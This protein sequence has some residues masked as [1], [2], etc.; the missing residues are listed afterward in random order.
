[1]YDCITSGV[2]NYNRFSKLTLSAFYNK[3]LDMDLSTLPQPIAI[4]DNV[5]DINAIMLYILTLNIYFI[6]NV[7]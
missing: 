6:I 7:I 1:M 3:L 5:N 4:A 2:V